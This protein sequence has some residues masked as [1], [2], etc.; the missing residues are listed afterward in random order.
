MISNYILSHDFQ[1]LSSG[2]E[3]RLWAR[4]GALLDRSCG[5]GSDLNAVGSEGITRLDILWRKADAKETHLFQ[6]HVLQRVV[7][8]FLDNGAKLTAKENDSLK[9]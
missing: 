7:L 9:E 3:R 4:F 2:D 8:R 6:Q 5:C 1:A